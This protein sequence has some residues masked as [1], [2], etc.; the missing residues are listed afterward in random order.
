MMK[1]AMAVPLPDRKSRKLNPLQIGCLMIVILVALLGLNNFLLRRMSN[2]LSKGERGR[3]VSIRNQPNI[4]LGNTLEDI[5]ALTKA[6]NEEDKQTIS[7]LILSGR[8]ST[9]LDGTQIEVIDSHMRFGK[10]RCLDGSRR[11]GWMLFKEISPDK[12]K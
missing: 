11:E 3:I 2:T 5:V 9:V 7:K 10:I 4:Y 6:T 12:P 1:N 8:I